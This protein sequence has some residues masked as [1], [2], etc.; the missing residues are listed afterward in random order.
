M[1][2]GP[3]TAKQVGAEP[4]SYAR[5]VKD[6]WF[7]KGEAARQ[8][9]LSDNEAAAHMGRYK[10]DFGIWLNLTNHH[11]YCRLKQAVQ[12]SHSWSAAAGSY[13]PPARAL[14]VALATRY[15]PVL[16]AAFEREQSVSRPIA[17][18]ALEQLEREKSGPDLIGAVIFV[19]DHAASHVQAPLTRPTASA[20]VWRS[21][22]S[23]VGQLRRCLSITFRLASIVHLHHA[24]DPSVDGVYEP[25]VRHGKRGKPKP[26]NDATC[27]LLKAHYVHPS[28]SVPLL[29]TSHSQG[30]AELLSIPNWLSHADVWEKYLSETE[31]KTINHLAKACTSVAALLTLR[32]NEHFTV[33]EAIAGVAKSP[34]NWRDG[35]VHLRW[36]KHCVE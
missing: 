36:S 13:K 19:E 35:A 23:A 4:M 10:S 11:V 6:F 24:A 8:A 30:H 27:K 21:C 2:L 5:F 29:V 18:A 26:L 25:F 22:A 20:E 17:R 16:R 34:A 12:H 14:P 33:E 7:L 15:P 31:T 28:H 9:S 3:P 1:S 32:L